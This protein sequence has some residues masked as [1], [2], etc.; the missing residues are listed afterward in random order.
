MKMTQWRL[1]KEKK[2]KE[3]DA[4]LKK[5]FLREFITVFLYQYFH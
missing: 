2:E 4:D 1:L 3:E 5:V